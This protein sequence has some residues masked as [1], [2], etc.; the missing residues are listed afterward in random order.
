[1]KPKTSEILLFL[2]G[3][4]LSDFQTMEIVLVLIKLLCTAP[5]GVPHTDGCLTV[6][7]HLAGLLTQHGGSL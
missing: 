1:L 4:Y 6:M 5:T 3:V 7:M 2:E